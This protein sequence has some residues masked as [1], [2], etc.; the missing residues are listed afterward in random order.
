MKFERFFNSNNSNCALS[1]IAHGNAMVTAYS[2]PVDVLDAIED[3]ETPRELLQNLKQ[4]RLVGFGNIVIDRETNKYV[5]VKGS[6]LLG[7]IHYIQASFN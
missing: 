3:A 7:N 2:T 6:D 4:L 5:R 1:N